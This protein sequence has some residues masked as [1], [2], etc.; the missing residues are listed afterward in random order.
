[1]GSGRTMTVAIVGF[2]GAGA[3]CWMLLAFLPWDLMTK[4][5]KGVDPGR[6]PD[7]ASVATVVAI[8]AIGIV[9]ASFAVVK[10]MHDDAKSKEIEQPIAPKTFEEK[11]ADQLASD[12]NFREFDP[13]EVMLRDGTTRRYRLFALEPYKRAGIETREVVLRAMGCCRFHGHRV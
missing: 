10:V 8:L 9:G 3:I 5:A 12:L 4:P 1:V 13:I 2:L 7:V 6:W 11:R